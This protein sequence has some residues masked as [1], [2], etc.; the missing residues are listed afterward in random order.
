MADYEKREQAIKEHRDILRAVV[1][2]NKDGIDDIIKKHLSNSLEV[3][4][5][6]I[7]KNEKKQCED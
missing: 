4:I 2:K 1:E 6:E 5:V 7:R 3:V